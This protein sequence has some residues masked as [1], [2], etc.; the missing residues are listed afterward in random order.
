MKLINC[1]K[2]PKPLRGLDIV[3]ASP[4]HEYLA[5]S[6]TW[7]KH[8]KQ[9]D[10]ITT[11]KTTVPKTILD[12]II[13]TRSMGHEFL[14][15]DQ[16]CIDQHDHSE[17]DFQ[18]SHM[19]DIYKG[20]AVTII[21]AAGEDANSGLPGVGDTPRTPQDNVSIGEVQLISSMHVPRCTIKS[22]KWSTRAWTYQE[23]ILSTRRLVFTE[24]ETYFECSSMHWRESWRGD[25]DSLHSHGRFCRFI[26]PGVFSKKGTKTCPTLTKAPFLRLQ[27]CYKAIRTYSTK[28]FSLNYGEKD[29]LMAFKGVMNDFETGE[30][31]VHQH[32]GV[33]FISS[34]KSP[35][36][37]LDSFVASL[38][39]RH[40]R[41]VLSV[42]PRPRRRPNFPSWSWAGWEGEVDFSIGFSR[43][44]RGFTSMISGMA[45]FE[46]HH[47]QPHQ[48]L[49]LTDLPTQLPSHEPGRP[50]PRLLGFSA[51]VLLPSTR[52]HEIVIS[53]RSKDRPNIVMAGFKAFAPLSTWPGGLENPQAFGTLFSSGKFEFVLLALELRPR[54]SELRFLVIES[55]SHEDGACRVGTLIVVAELEDFKQ[56]FQFERREILIK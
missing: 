28:E 14:W 35:R 20:A 45:F 52:L 31:P 2:S 46:T 18:M 21:A 11:N 19:N 43:L 54:R 49:M 48:R 41:S 6:Y 50:N 51:P 44:R 16:Y 23:G 36:A 32:W 3:P 38:L 4:S 5:L 55:G 15:V 29:S 30:H 56:T 37:V 39:W 10:S 40:T 8:D 47:K 7:G 24:Y 1:A 33:P 25:W 17:K 13:V 53:T 12:S 34:V 9:G 27:N 42:S 26:L 22:S